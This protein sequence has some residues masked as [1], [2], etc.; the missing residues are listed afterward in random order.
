MHERPRATRNRKRTVRWLVALRRRNPDWNDRTVH[1]ERT[2]VIE[3]SVPGRRVPIRALDGRAEKGGVVVGDEAV[4]LKHE[5]AEP[6]TVGLL[7]DFPPA[8]STRCPSLDEV[9]PLP[10]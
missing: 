2:K 9:F 6:R 4:E 10:Q 1:P 7:Q 3:G 8:A 5:I